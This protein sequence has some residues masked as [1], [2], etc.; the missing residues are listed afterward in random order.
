MAAGV[1]VVYND[2]F[3]VV[4]FNGST[5]THTLP[6]QLWPD[7]SEPNPNKPFLPHRM[8]WTDIAGVAGDQV[9]LQSL[10]SHDWT[11]FVATGADYQAPQ[12]WKRAKGEPGPIGCKITR[13][14]S[15]EL[16]IY[17]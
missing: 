12:E 1:D 13:F 10:Q 17:L 5:A 4:T 14:D 15:G 16:I 6:F 3:W 11:H 7:V 9:I 2:T 8:V